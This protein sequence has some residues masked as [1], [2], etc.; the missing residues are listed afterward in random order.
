M[1]VIAQLDLKF[2]KMV[3]KGR[4]Y[5]CLWESHMQRTWSVRELGVLV[6][7]HVVQGEC[8]GSGLNGLA[9]HGVGQAVRDRINKQKQGQAGGGRYK[10][11]LYS[12]LIFTFPVANR[13]SKQ[14]ATTTAGYLLNL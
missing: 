14:S 9:R 3:E 6:W 5:Y 12:M 1:K 8:R 7:L 2:E 4:R 10:K 11:T 13:Y